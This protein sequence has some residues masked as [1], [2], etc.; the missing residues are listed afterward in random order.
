MIYLLLSISLIFPKTFHTEIGQCT[1]EIYDGKIKNIPEL[2]DIIKNEAKILVTNLGQVK[3]KPFSIHITNDLSK[4]NKMAGPV[5]EWGIAIA[6]NKVNKIIMQSPNL[7][8]ISY[9]KFKKVLKH[10]LNH[11]YIFQMPRYETIPSWFK[12]GLAMYYSNEFSISHKIEISNFL[13]KQKIVPLTKLQTI[14]K[15]DNI[16]L[17]YAESAAAIES[18]IY[19]YGENIIIKIFN[20]LHLNQTFELALENAINTPYINFQNNFQLFLNENY[21]WV[22]L[23]KSGKHFFVI[24]PFMLIFGFYYKSYKNKKIL[25]LWQLEE[26]LD[27]Y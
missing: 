15:Y 24:L 21:K 4:F 1:M 16:T 20:N 18:L 10:E 14:N 7:A 12:E 5:P 8:R 17:Q 9:S 23:L 25:K 27:N 13:W 22:F 26:E 6:K 19:Y 11:I 2:I 3:Q